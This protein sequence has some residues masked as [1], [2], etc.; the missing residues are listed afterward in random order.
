MS[1]ISIDLTQID[2]YTSYHSP[3]HPLRITTDFRVRF[4]K[5]HTKN[6]MSDHNEIVFCIRYSIGV[7]EPNVSPYIR[8]WEHQVRHSR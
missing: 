6:V 5:D 2:Y 8:T 7:K 3:L 1:L 4:A